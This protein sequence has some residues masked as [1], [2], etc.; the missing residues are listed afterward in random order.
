MYDFYFILAT[1]PLAFLFILIILV[2][3]VGGAFPKTL[4]AFDKKLSKLIGGAE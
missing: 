1:I 3:V 4:K 2:G